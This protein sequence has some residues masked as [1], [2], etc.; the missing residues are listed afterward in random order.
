MDRDD[1]GRKGIR[2]KRERMAQIA[3]RD[4]GGIIDVLF[5]QTA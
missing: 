2:S 5:R 4:Y 3:G 1:C